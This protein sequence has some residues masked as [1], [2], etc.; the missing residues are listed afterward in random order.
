VVIEDLSGGLIVSD[1]LFALLLNARVSNWVFAMTLASSSCET[2]IRKSCCAAS[3]DQLDLRFDA[4]ANVLGRYGSDLL[5]VDWSV[6]RRLVVSQGE[7]GGGVLFWHEERL[8]VECA[9]S[10][11]ICELD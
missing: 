10:H 9:D 2:E 1:P 6:G 5:L 11:A 8:T 3:R 7:F 4:V